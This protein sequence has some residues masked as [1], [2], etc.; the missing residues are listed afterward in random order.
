M[1][2]YFGKPRNWWVSPIAIITFFR[3][4]LR[5]PQPDYISEKPWF[6][7]WERRMRPWCEWVSELGKR[8]FPTSHTV[9]VDEWDVYSPKSTF[10]D[11]MVPV[12]KV[13]RDKTFSVPE[14]DQ[15]DLPE[16]LRVEKEGKFVDNSA[17]AIHLNSD[18]GEPELGL[19]QWH[20][21]LNEIIWSLEQDDDCFLH[22]LRE[23]RAALRERLINGHRLLGKYYRHLWW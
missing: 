4:V 16:Y 13:F 23:H 17:H 8:W 10:S 11:V 15:N 19:K 2:V 22:D 3:R 1:Y 14:I 6:R 21:I 9:R 18:M 12:L 20:F 5:Y 7:T